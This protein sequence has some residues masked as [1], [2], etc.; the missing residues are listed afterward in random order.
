[1]SGDRILPRENLRNKGVFR[2]K[3]PDLRGF[4]L[5]A[6]QGDQISPEGWWGG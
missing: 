4:L 1:M 5:K 2:I 6:G 3:Q